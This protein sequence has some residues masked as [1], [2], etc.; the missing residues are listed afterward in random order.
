MRRILA[1]LDTEYGLHVGDRGPERQV[2][3]AAELVCSYPY[4]CWAGW[5][6]SQE[7]PRSDLRG[8]VAREL[9]HDPIDA[10]FDE[11]ALTREPDAVRAD[12]ILQNGARLYNDHG[13][14]E[15]ATPECLSIEELVLHDRTGDKAVNAAGQEFEKRTGNKVG[16][17][18]NN[19][20]FHGASYGC[21]ENYLVPRSVG[22]DRLFNGLAPMLV[23]RQVLCGAGKVGAES[24]AKCDFQISQ[25]A[26]FINEVAS[27][28]TLFK[29]P[30]FNTRD[31]PHADAEKWMRLH[32]ICGDANMSPTALSLK[33]GL[34]KVALHTIEADCAPQWELHD[35]VRA[36]REASRAVES[37]GTIE[38][39]RSSQ[40]TPRRVIESYLDAYE[41]NFGAD[42]ELDEIVLLARRLLDK[43]FSDPVLFARSVDWASK[44]RLLTMFQEED[45][46]EWSDPSL[47]SLDLEYHRIDGEGGLHVSLVQSDEVDPEPKPQEVERRT[48]TI[49]EPTR[50]LARSVAVTKFSDR[51]SGAN[52]RYLTFSLQDGMKRVE[53]LPDRNYPASL[54]NASSVE[55][56]IMQIEEANKNG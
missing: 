5:D 25:R 1:G 7:S 21:H 39:Q 3:D 33:V 43:R 48:G 15:Y 53:L 54:W 17:Y 45:S 47:Q 8:F 22:F 32:V 28:D 2:D 16:I 38:I 37:E 42:S 13:H 24:G 4:D 34:V 26:D 29:R 19:T 52:W 27:V 51:L 46:L 41:E 35:P 18:K 44:K 12:R 56:L 36:F 49:E 14:P 11:R 10:Q 55:E 20:D 40:T 6:A 9:Q 30:L 50:A 31:E 23:A